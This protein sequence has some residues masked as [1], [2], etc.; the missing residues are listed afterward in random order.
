D[1]VL[2]KNQTDATENGIRVA[3]AGQ[4][5]RAPDA[6][7]S[8][9]MQKGTTVYVQ[10]GTVHASH[11]FSFQTFEPVIGDDDIVLAFY[12][13]DDTVGDIAA[14]L[15]AAIDD[16]EAAGEAAEGSIADLMGSVTQVFGTIGAASAY[17]PTAA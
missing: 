10:Q 3:S 6:R 16:V 17:S 2:V 7:T 4:W 15:A 11:V 9:S 1:R 12:L 14:A 5:Y 8:R 13:S